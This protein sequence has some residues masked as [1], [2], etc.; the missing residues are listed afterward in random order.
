MLYHGLA[1][2][3][4]CRCVYSENTVVTPLLEPVTWTTCLGQSVGGLCSKICLVSDFRQGVRVNWLDCNIFHLVQY[5]TLIPRN[6]QSV[7]QKCCT[8][9]RCL[10][11]LVY[12]GAVIQRKFKQQQKNWIYFLDLSNNK[13]DACRNTKHS[14]AVLFGPSCYCVSFTKY[15]QCSLFGLKQLY[16][17]KIVSSKL[18]FEW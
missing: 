18:K 15:C 4:C 11:V 3:M 14:A 13:K 8:G 9:W 2:W 1:L 7:M 5:Y 17:V 12:G 10:L 16:Q 6:I